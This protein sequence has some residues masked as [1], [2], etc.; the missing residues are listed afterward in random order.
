MTASADAAG[1]GPQ[2]PADGGGR[3]GRQLRPNDP[4]VA[5][6]L[7]RIVRGCSS[8]TMDLLRIGE[9]VPR[10][11]RLFRRATLYRTILFKYPNFGGD[12]PGDPTSGRLG[13][14]PVETG[15]YVPNDAADPMGGGFAM[16]LHRPAHR[17]ALREFV[18]SGED[19]G[20][21]ERDL[22]VLS[23]IDEIPTT[24][25]FLVKSRLEMAEVAVPDGALAIRPREEAAMRAIIEAK[26]GPILRKAFARH[27]GLS[28]EALRRALDA[29][30]DP[31]M[32]EGRAFVAAF[33]IEEARV[34][35]I[36]F[37]LQGITFY[38]YLFGDTRDRLKDVGVWLAGPAARPE[39][40][41]RIARFDLERAAML[42]VQVQ[43]GIART[44]RELYAVFQ[45]YDTA[46]DAF[47]RDRGAGPLVEFLGGAEARFWR[48][49]HGLSAL[50]N[51]CIAV[52]DLLAKPVLASRYDPVSDTL[53]RL[54]VILSDRADAHAV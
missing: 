52:E 54:R 27:G 5:P 28:P 51:A 12:R 4:S 30:W 34:G 9:G 17:A 21:L 23:L 22:A 42:R 2:R 1:E 8:T 16:F 13:A 20:D 35:R 37:A 49:G 18:G 38:E 36:F 19:P 40:A 53:S 15:V 11:R 32:A 44:L 45:A 3:P 24:D 31:R 6:V 39:D 7:H 46:L 47:S 14:K 26:I 10:H 29:I 41:Q 33:G 43:G 48:I 25:P 50:V